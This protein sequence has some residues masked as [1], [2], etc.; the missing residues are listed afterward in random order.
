MH[1]SRFAGQNS[2]NWP[3]LGQKIKKFVFISHMSML[4]TILKQILYRFLFLS[5][6]IEDMSPLEGIAYGKIL[7]LP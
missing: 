6:K 7:D 3:N 2:G 1:F 5:L 4:Y